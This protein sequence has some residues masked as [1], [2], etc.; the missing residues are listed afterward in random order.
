M[1]VVQSQNPGKDVM[2]KRSL[3]SAFML[4]SL[5]LGACEY[6][7]PKLTFD[8]SGTPNPLYYGGSCGVPVIT[9]NVTGFLGDY[10]YTTYNPTVA[11]ELFDGA[12]NKIK[13]GKLALSPVAL[14]TPDAYLAS[15]EIK[16]PESGAPASAPD[17][18]I[19]D[20]GEGSIRFQAIIE[21]EIR[22]GPTTVGGRGYYFTSTKSIPI[23]PCP[24]T[25]KATIE[26]RL[27]GLDSA[28]LIAPGSSDKPSKPGG[29]APP[30]PPSCSTDPN[31]PSCV[32]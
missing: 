9:F 19:L 16:I 24:P 14:A 30:A 15:Q 23:L 13:A 12:G 4:A 32:P 1:K 18:L 26:P 11:Y 10:L 28:T 17:S 5:I 7:K 22:T 3:I 8:I 27:P 21:A 29:G 31:N 2:N 6:S 25:M 20:F